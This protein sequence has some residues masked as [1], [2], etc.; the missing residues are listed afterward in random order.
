MGE[1]RLRPPFHDNP[2]VPSCVLDSI[3]AGIMVVDRSGTCVY[4]NHECTAITGHTLED[5]LADQGLW[6]Q[7]SFGLLGGSTGG[8]GPQEAFGRSVTDGQIPIACRD[9]Q[10]KDVRV[11]VALQS[12]GSALV[13]LVHVSAQAAAETVPDRWDRSGR[14]LIEHMPDAVLI[15]DLG[16]KILAYNAAF[17]DLFGFAAAEVD[18][19]FL[20]GSPQGSEIDQNVLRRV[21]AVPAITGGVT[22]EWDFQKKDGAVIRIASSTSPIKRHDG[23]LTGY[24]GLMREVTGRVTKERD[25]GGAEDKFRDLAEKSVALTGV[26][27]IEGGFFRYVNQRFAEMYGYTIEEIVDRKGP[28]DLVLPEDW[29][30]FEQLVLMELAEDRALSVHRE[31]RGLNRSNEII[32]LDLYASRTRV[33]N[34]QAIIGT[35]LDITDRK[36]TEERLRKAEEKYRNIFENSVLG[37]FQTTP[38]GKFLSANRAVARIHGYDSPEELKRE[39]ND[40]GKDFYVSPERRAEFLRLMEEDGYVEGFEAEMRKKDGSTNWVSLS[41]RAVRDETGKILCFEGTIQE[42]TERKTLE[43]QLLQSQKMEAIGTLAGGVAHDFNNLLMGIQGYTS[44]MLFNMQPGQ[45]HYDRLRNIEHLV[46][47]GAD[48]TKQLL[49]FARGGRYEI[50]ITDLRE[51]LSNVS[52]MFMRTKKEITVHE[53]YEPDLYPVEVDRGQME[54]AFL[55]LYVNA[56]QAMPSGGHLYIEAE[57]VILD[58]NYLRLYSMNPGKYVKISVTDTGVGM[59]EKTMERIFEPFFTTKEMGRG[60]GLGLASVYGIIKGHKGFINVYSQLGHGTAFSVYLPASKKLGAAESE[61]S[62]DLAMGTE[63]ILL[64]DDE[65]VILNVGKEIIET[66][67]YH[68]LVASGGLEAIDIYS[69]N[70]KEIAAIILDMVMPDLDGGKTFDALKGIEPDVKVILSSGYSLNS[71][72]EGIM[73]R[74]C[75]AFMQKPFNVHAISRTLRQVLDGYPTSSN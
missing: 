8:K 72:A 44:L 66:L 58:R 32:H 16:G 17:L 56:W 31:F 11:R 64:V 12:D 24:V 37:I 4:L 7:I 10:I 73:Q 28:Q 22:A 6:R 20:P 27:L 67:G 48:L 53:K 49:G 62:E 18:G 39:V 30:D 52:A 3:R 9:G 36:V 69:R 35:L 25:P 50:K 15:L 54:H 63:T 45:E 60:T 57:N 14:A 19:G 34:D 40:I 42:I 33:D 61:A 59:D 70:R 75:K 74:G 26:F 29:P 23:L 41:A 51:V 1:E 13:T 68:V 46:R 71:E 55:N 2:L 38:Q 5:V 47:S 21:F 65:A 43:S